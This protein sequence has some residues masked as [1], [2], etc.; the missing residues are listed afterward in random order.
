VLFFIEVAEDMF[1]KPKRRDGWI[2][3]GGVALLHGPHDGPNVHHGLSLMSQITI[4]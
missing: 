3:S 2:V 4:T 1:T